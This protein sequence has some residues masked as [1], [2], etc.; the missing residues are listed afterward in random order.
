MC[1]IPK[2]TTRFA[3]FDSKFKKI[4]RYALCCYR[5]ATISLVLMNSTIGLYF[6]IIIQLLVYYFEHIMISERR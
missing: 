2:I 1:L 5:F 3:I 4:Q 6:S